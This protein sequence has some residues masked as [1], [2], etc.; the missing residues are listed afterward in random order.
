MSKTTRILVAVQE[1]VERVGVQ[2]LLSN[3]VRLNVVAETD[4]REHAIRLCRET[5]PDVILTTL[6]VAGSKPVDFVTRLHRHCPQAK[7]LFWSTRCETACLNEL[8]RAG[9]AGYLLKEA[10]PEAVLKTIQA[11]VEDVICFSQ[12]TISKLV[13]QKESES[14][15]IK[16]L[17]L[18]QREQQIL[19]LMAQGKDNTY[20]AAIL[21]LSPQTV[22][23]YSSS[24]Y[25]KLGVSSRSEA[26]LW[27][28]E[29]A[30]E[31]E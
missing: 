11:I 1:P 14:D 28:K 6:H 12:S 13:E 26:I 3:D 27:V 10:T 7:I 20:I 18:T 29:N 30:L 23:N 15:L 17:G 4:N 19:D 8:V 5:K 21:E 16:A 2:T 24:L 25:T 9:V 22:R 31:K